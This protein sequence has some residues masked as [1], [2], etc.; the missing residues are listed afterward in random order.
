MIL[1]KNVDPR[2]LSNISIVAISVGLPVAD[3]NP[4]PAS[5]VGLQQFREI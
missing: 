2:V 4:V 5:Q 1:T 3:N